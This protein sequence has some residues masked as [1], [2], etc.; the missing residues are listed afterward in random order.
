MIVMLLSFSTPSLNIIQEYLNVALPIW[1]DSL[2][3][4]LTKSL[5]TAPVR[6]KR[7]PPVVDL[8]QSTCPR[9]TRLKCYLCCLSFSMRGYISFINMK[10]GSEIKK[11]NWL[12][13][14]IS[15]VI[16][17]DYLFG[18]NRSL[19]LLVFVLML[20]VRGKTESRASDALTLTPMLASEISRP[21]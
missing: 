9:R 17:K 16:S 6:Y 3:H 13:R 21:Q 15:Q 11:I 8:P 5:P 12:I 4:L 18:M 20:G 10:N 2:S 7:C 19:L 1:A 14:L